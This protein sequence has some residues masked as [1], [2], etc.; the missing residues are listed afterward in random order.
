MSQAPGCRCPHQQRMGRSLQLGDAVLARAA[1]CAACAAA[2]CRRQ[3]QSVR[4][5]WGA[6]GAP[7]RCLPAREAC[8]NAAVARQACRARSSE[9]RRAAHACT[10]L[11]LQPRARPLGEAGERIDARAGAQAQRPQRDVCVQ[12]HSCCLCCS[13]SGLNDVC[14]ARGAV[15]MRPCLPH[16]HTRLSKLPMRAPGALPRLASSVTDQCSIDGCHPQRAR[17][18]RG[19]MAA[20]PAPPHGNCA[21]RGAQ[22]SPGSPCCVLLPVLPLT[23]LVTTACTRYFESGYTLHSIDIQR[24]AMDMV[25]GRLQEHCT[26]LAVANA[27]SLTSWR[28]TGIGRAPAARQ[29]SL[30]VR[31]GMRCRLRTGCSAAVS[32]PAHRAGHAKSVATQA[33][34]A[35]LDATCPPIC[36]CLVL[37][38]RRA[39]PKAAANAQRRGTSGGST[40]T[41]SA[42]SGAAK[43]SSVQRKH[44]GRGSVPS[45]NLAMNP[46]QPT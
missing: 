31:L 9:K 38:P 7:C 27:S 10:H 43:R 26:R 34:A 39:Q 24:C 3:R 35:V 14:N 11:V 41:R 42:G 40:C 5:G 37:L 30:C 36:T 2:A 17:T 29:R 20:G 33:G 15:P 6:G 28:Q 25:V 12:P 19:P 22:A 13:P 18:P 32:E 23:A 16:E 44:A 45:A 8:C 46:H 1:A 4:V 21:S